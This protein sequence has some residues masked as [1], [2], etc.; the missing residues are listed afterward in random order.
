VELVFGSFVVSE[1]D[2]KG[3]SYLVTRNISMCKLVLKHH[4]CA[5]LISFDKF[6]VGSQDATWRS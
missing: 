4:F 5:D 2:V 6:L 3:H 1:G